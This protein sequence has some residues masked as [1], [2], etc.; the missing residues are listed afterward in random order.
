MVIKKR[1]KQKTT[2]KISTRAR[3]Y[4]YRI[5]KQLKLE[6]SAQFNAAS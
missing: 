4:T 2:T 5:T 1:Q 6:D 3:T